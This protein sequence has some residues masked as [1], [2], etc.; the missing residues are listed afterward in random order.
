MGSRDPLDGFFHPEAY[1]FES[2]YKYGS[3]GQNCILHTLFIAQFCNCFD[4]SSSF[5]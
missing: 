1:C 5:S 2:N 3:T 4:D